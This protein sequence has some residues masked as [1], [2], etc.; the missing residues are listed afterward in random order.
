MP[1]SIAVAVFITVTLN[2]RINKELHRTRNTAS[3]L[4]CIL[5]LTIAIWPIRTGELFN[6]TSRAPSLISVG[7]RSGAGLWNDLIDEVSRV[8]QT[9]KV[10]GIVTDTVTQF[11]LDAAVFG[12]TPKRDSLQY[13][14]ASNSNYQGDLLFSDFS[15]HLLIVNLRDGDVTESARFAGHWPKDALST[16]KLYPPD[17]LAFSLANPKKFVPIWKKDSIFIFLIQPPLN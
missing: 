3:L 5:A 6:R 16:S 8:N 10:K 4:L 15:Q 11:V 2:E 7:P 17:I 9:R 1:T 13:F 12:K 14:P